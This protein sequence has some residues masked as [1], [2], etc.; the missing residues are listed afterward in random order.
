MKQDYCG[1][2][3]AWSK[4]KHSWQLATGSIFSI[5]VESF[6]LSAA[7]CPLLAMT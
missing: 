7:S 6:Y 3:K 1:F 5:A 4:G 2:E